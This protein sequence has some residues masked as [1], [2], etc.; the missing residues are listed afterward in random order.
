VATDVV[1]V[2]KLV[3]GGYC[4]GVDVVL[5]H[6]TLLEGV[7]HANPAGQTPQTAF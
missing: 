5:S 4:V 3:N 7:E 2:V 6:V 1:A